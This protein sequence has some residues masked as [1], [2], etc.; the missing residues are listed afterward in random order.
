VTFVEQGVLS[1]GDA[2]TRTISG[3]KPQMLGVKEVP[4]ARACLENGADRAEVSVEPGDGVFAHAVLSQS[5]A[6]SEGN[7]VFAH[8]IREGNPQIAADVGSGRP[9]ELD[10][11]SPPRHGTVERWPLGDLMRDKL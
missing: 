7:G 9:Q 4:V 10:L 11:E 8:A 6:S 3:T 5:A 1:G 2:L